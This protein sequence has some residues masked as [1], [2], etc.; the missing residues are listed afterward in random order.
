[1]NPVP[2]EIKYD[3]DQMA[4]DFKSAKKE[5]PIKLIKV[6]EGVQ[7]ARRKDITASKCLYI[8]RLFLPQLQRQNM[9]PGPFLMLPSQFSILPNPFTKLL[10]PSQ[11]RPNVNAVKSNALT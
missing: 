7:E 11:R 10:R 9:I 3:Y 4:Q 8:T 6:T 1:M 5:A 2:T